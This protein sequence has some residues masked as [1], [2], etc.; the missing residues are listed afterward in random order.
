MGAAFMLF[1]VFFAQAFES[2]V[3]Q[4]SN[5]GETRSIFC[6]WQKQVLRAQEIKY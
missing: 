1:K 3:V 4:K 5:C 2:E 6:Q